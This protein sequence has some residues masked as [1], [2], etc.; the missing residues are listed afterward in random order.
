MYRAA[1]LATVVVVDGEALVVVVGLVRRAANFSSMAVV[2]AV[3]WCRGV[4]VLSSS[5]SPGVGR[6]LEVTASWFVLARRAAA[7]RR[8]PRLRSKTLA[9]SFW[10]SS[11]DGND[12]DADDD[13][14]PLILL[15]L[16]AERWL[17]GDSASEG[18][19]R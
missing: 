1:A 11:L 12:D 4:V 18:D 15:L 13:D 2:A 16:T 5:S 19:R 17:V 6:L 3:A 8:S 10:C 14:D 9:R 7:V